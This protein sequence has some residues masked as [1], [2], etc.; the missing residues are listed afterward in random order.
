MSGHKE[1][2]KK[3]LLMPIECTTQS[4][5]AIFTHN[6]KI[7][8]SQKYKGILDPDMSDIAVGFYNIVYE[9]I[10]SKDGLLKKDDYCN[11]NFLGDTMNSFNSIANIVPEAGKSVKQRTD[12]KMWPSFLQNYH[13]S[14]HCLSNFW[15][16]PR[17]IGRRGKKFNSHDSVDIF[18]N[19]LQKDYSILEKYPDYFKQMN[20]YGKFY[21]K[22][23]LTNI[24]TNIYTPLSN[25][26]IKSLYNCKK[27]DEKLNESAKELIDQAQN[28]WELRANCISSDHNICEKLYQYFSKL[29][30]LPEGANK[31]AN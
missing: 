6:D 27:V 11:D 18:L 21:Q 7:F 5:I 30:I 1:Q 25:C 12:W 31:L 4:S 19:I 23:F 14:Y 28:C 13:S 24:D 2:V 16:L 8:S 26:K 15:V 22:H 29:G 20:T 10:L 17:N 3:I 9:D